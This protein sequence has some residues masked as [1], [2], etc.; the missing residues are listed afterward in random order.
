MQTLIDAIEA[1]ET[2]LLEA[3]VVFGHGTTNAFDEAAW[4]TLWRLGLPLTDLA[5]HESDVL[6]LE[7]ISAV[8]ALIQER[9][10]SRKPAAYLT[11]EAWLQGVPFYVDERCIVP[12]SLIAEP[13][14][15][16]TLDLW[17]PEDCET[18]RILDLC[19]GNGSLAVLA[20][21]CYETASVV[22]ADLSPDALAVARINGEKHSL[23]PRIEW[24]QSDSL[25]AV[26]GV[27]DMVLCNPPYVNQASMDALPQE[28]LAEP[29]LALAGGLDGMNFV[30]GL[31]KVVANYLTPQGF[32][33]LEIG[34]EKAFFD[35]AFPAL[36]PVWLDTSGGD[37][38][39][40]LL[41][42]EDLQ[43]TP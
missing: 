28:F 41:R 19:T 22:G 26:N 25:T 43:P 42:R 31:L 13:L 30:R 24:L 2:Q 9:I 29:A 17:L 39:V 4:L 27:F 10:I 16:G 34:H 5:V 21:L 7:Q 11:R 18:P 33:V 8:Q 1:A 36:N 40:L 35:A 32:L 23:Q 15:A 14:C 38:Q 6:S 3:H 37:E 12:R 20:A